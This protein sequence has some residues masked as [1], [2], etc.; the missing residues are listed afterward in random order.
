MTLHGEKK[1]G[2]AVKSLEQDGRPKASC[3]TFLGFKLL[4][5][6]IT[7]IEKF[8]K[9]HS[10]LRSSVTFHSSDILPASCRKKPHVSPASHNPVSRNPCK[11][12]PGN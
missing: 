1:P 9:A 5:Y 8:G 3:L 2:L 12:S 10:K 11:R 4:L 7:E 6:Y